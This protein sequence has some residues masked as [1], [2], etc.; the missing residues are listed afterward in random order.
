M[1]RVKRT[2]E[3]KDNKAINTLK[4]VGAFVNIVGFY[5]IIM[6]TAAATLSA[7]GAANEYLNTNLIDTL[8][9]I[10]KNTYLTVTVSMGLV[11]IYELINYVV[12][13]Y[14]AKRLLLISVIIEIG[15]LVVLCLFQGLQL[16]SVPVYTLILPIISGLI[17]YFILV[18]ENNK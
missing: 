14:K 6:L 15:T 4:I 16:I 13:L 17:N 12:Y 2:E 9:T 3:E 7:V 8:N 11:L 10:A 18:L 5:I 1:A